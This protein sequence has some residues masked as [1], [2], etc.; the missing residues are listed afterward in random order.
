MTLRTFIVLLTGIWAA[1][2]SESAFGQEIRAQ[3]SADSLRPGEVFEFRIDFD[4]ARTYDAVI[5]PDSTFFGREFFVR[6]KELSRR[7]RTATYE[8][9]FF[10]TGDMVLD[11]LAIRAVQAGDT[12]LLAVPAVGFG[13][14]SVLQ[15]VDNLR[16]MKPIFEFPYSIQGLI[17][18]FLLAMLAAISAWHIYN[19]Y[20]RKAPPPP[21]PVPVAPPV[22]DNPLKR[23]ERGIAELEQGYAEKKLSVED[24]YF[25]ISFLLREYY[26]RVYRFQALEQ[27]SREVLRGLKVRKVPSAHYEK[28]AQLLTVSD[29]V[30]F[31]GFIPEHDDILSDLQSLRTS[32]EQLRKQNSGLIQ[33]MEMEHLRLY[34]VTEPANPAEVPAR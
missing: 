18:A 12:L 7:S 22:F 9:Q 28:A 27:T 23:L 32:A 25:K 15:P 3:A 33:Q 30:K 29:M 31:A 11:Q 34:R 10:G 4:A 1:A 20:F 14:R 5:Y 2:F 21:P 26:E 19:R 13:F 6:N 8:L 24:L 17:F 16:P